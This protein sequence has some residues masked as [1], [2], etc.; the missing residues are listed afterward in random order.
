MNYQQEKSDR[1][2]TVQAYLSAHPKARAI[3]IARAT[4]CTE[5]EALVFLSE[6]VWTLPKTEFRRILAEIQRWDRVMVLVRNQD[7]VAEVEVPGQL[8]YLNG[9][10]LNWIDPEYNLH[11]RH[12]ATEQI[13]ALIRPGKRGLTYSF[14]LVNQTG[15]VFCRFYTRTPAA[16]E[17]FLSFIETISKT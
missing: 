13:L 3:D 14:N 9:D 1:Q 8:G 16:E 17:R 2:A 4:G 6:K 7:G 10:W 15:Y 11:I 12:A 5:A